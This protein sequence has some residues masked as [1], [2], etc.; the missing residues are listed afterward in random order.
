MMEK[1]N[2][3]KAM[4]AMRTSI[5]HSSGTPLQKDYRDDAIA[6]ALIAIAETLAEINQK[7]TAVEHVVYTPGKEG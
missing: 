3:E 6:Y 1:T 5:R 7:M 2:L 4:I